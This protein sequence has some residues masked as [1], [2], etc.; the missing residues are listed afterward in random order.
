QIGET[1]DPLSNQL[2]M[3]DDVARMSNDTRANDLAVRKVQIFKKMILVLVPGICRLKAVR[4]CVDLEDIRSNLSQG[5]L[6]KTGTF[7]NP[8]AGVEAYLFRRDAAERRVG[9]LDIDLCSARLLR[10]VKAGLDENIGQER[11]VDLNEQP[12]IDDAAI[13][14][15]KLVRDGVK[16][17]LFGLVI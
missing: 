4:S 16:I 12:R 15:V 6:V 11:I 1:Q 2:G 8:V 9:R 3:F 7:V 5:G 10:V 13:F 17:C 14:L